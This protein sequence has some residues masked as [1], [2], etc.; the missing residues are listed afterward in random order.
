MRREVDKE[1]KKKL[2]ELKFLHGS[3][4]ESPLYWW[5]QTYQHRKNEIK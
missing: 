1:W 2:V 3:Q 4:L 5:E